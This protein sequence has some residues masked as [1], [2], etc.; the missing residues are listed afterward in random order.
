MAR[1]RNIIGSLLAEKKVR[2]ILGGLLI[3]AIVVFIGKKITSGSN[4]SVTQVASS[5]LNSNRSTSEDKALATTPVGQ[6]IEIPTGR[7]DNTISYTIV[8]AEITKSI[9]LQGER[10]RAKEGKQFLILNLK[11][12]NDSENR[13][14]I[15]TRDYVRLSVNGH[16]DR[17]PASVFNEIEVQPISDQY[18]RIG[19]SVFE[20]DTDYKLYL[21]E[22]TGEKTEIPVS[23][24]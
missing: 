12:S 11:L 10:A 20:K 24:K 4:N 1:S 6:T 14:Q 2:I 19:F 3:V 16:D 17:L 15:N 23:F 5:A 9:I 8:D 21:G 13:V 22:I 18:T 7:G